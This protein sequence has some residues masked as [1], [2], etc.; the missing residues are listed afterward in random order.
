MLL[1]TYNHCLI[2]AVKF[3]MSGG[4]NHTLYTEIDVAIYKVEEKIFDCYKNVV[5]IQCLKSP[6]AVKWPP[7]K[8]ATH[9]YHYALV[10][11]KARLYMIDEEDR[12]RDARFFDEKGNRDI[13]I[14]TGACMETITERAQ[15]ADCGDRLLIKQL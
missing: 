6:D 12:S 9:E 3:K 13:Y 8:G 7:P 10:P 4:G 5:Q 11:A 15:G 14:Y 1:Y 2:A